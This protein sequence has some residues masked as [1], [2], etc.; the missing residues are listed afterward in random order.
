MDNHRTTA[1][2]RRVISVQLYDAGEPPV[3]DIR[4][5]L[6]EAHRPI[7]APVDGHRISGGRGFLNGAVSSDV[8][9]SVRRKGTASTEPHKT[10]RPFHGAYYM[11]A[12]FNSFA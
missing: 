12:T 10:V 6:T 8:L 1:R 4:R 11:P 3:W 5:E 2:L 9:H 7:A